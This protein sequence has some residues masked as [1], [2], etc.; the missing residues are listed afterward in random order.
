MFHL[1]LL[2]A[3]PQEASMN[4]LEEEGRDGGERERALGSV[5][6]SSD[7]P[8]PFSVFK[9]YFNLLEVSLSLLPPLYS[10]N[11]GGNQ[12]PSKTRSSLQYRPVCCT[13]HCGDDDWTFICSWHLPGMVSSYRSLLKLQVFTQ[14]E[15]QKGDIR[16]FLSR[17]WPRCACLY[18]LVMF[19]Q[20]ACVCLCVFQ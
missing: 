6:S 10:K 8:Y 20:S 12:R 19:L 3:V 15:R 11:P 17:L 9:I 1:L 2:T 7:P 18:T 4:K 5:L 13:K 14:R 16:N